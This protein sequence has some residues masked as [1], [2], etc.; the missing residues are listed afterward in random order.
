MFLFLLNPW[1][2]ER[3]QPTLKL[4]K[5]SLLDTCTLS[6]VYPLL[7]APSREQVVAHGRDVP[8]FQQTHQ[9]TLIDTYAPPST[10]LSGLNWFTMLQQQ[11]TANHA[12]MRRRIIVVFALVVGGVC[13]CV[14][15]GV[16]VHVD[17]NNVKAQSEYRQETSRNF[18]GARSY[19]K[20]NVKRFVNGFAHL[21]IPLRK[22]ENAARRPPCCEG[23]AAKPACRSRCQNHTADRK[24]SHSHT[25]M[26]DSIM[27][28]RTTKRDLDLN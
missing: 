20:L 10:F 14:G 28:K 27:S 5:T 18:I 16:R 25:K 3:T 17:D 22:I 9:I 21:A 24:K 4:Q 6:Y 11:I 8:Q 1:T 19:Y 23:S 12:A 7:R 13:A 26:R 2:M 15:K